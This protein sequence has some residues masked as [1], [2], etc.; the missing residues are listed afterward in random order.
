MT[1]CNASQWISVALTDL[2][3][4]LQVVT[5]IVSIVGTAKGKVEQPVLDKVNSIGA[6]V[7]TDLATAQDLVSKFQTASKD[8]QPGMLTQ[9]DAALNTALQNLNEILG[10]LTITDAQL[11]ATIAAALGSAITV[12]VAITALVPAP[13]NPAPTPQSARR[14]EL[15]ASAKKDGSEL[16][17][18]S[19]N[20]IIG[21]THAS[22]MI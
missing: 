13:P 19:F 4:V 17:K 22:S 1:G 11:Q 12:V 15:K 7:K 9:I 20:I 21:R 8:A 6:I 14:V 3:T 2:P 5:S 16:I 10:A 18:E